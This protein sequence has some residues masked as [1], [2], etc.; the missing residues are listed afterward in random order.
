MRVGMLVFSPG[1]LPL[2]FVHDVPESVAAPWRG[3]A[4]GI[5]QG[6]L[7][8]ANVLAWSAPDIFRGKDMI[9]FIDNT[10]AESALVKSGS[11]T[12]SMSRLALQAAAFFTALGAR[13]WFEHIPSEDNPSDALSRAGF[14]DP[15]VAQMIASGQWLRMPCRA[16]PSADSFVGAWDLLE[17]LG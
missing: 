1:S 9:W 11:A 2:A 5:N 14:A 10:S 6:E 4:E 3:E 15:F 16:P 17:S 12:E 13:V 7:Y 8:A